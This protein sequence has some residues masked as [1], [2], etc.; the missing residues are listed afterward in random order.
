MLSQ[1]REEQMSSQDPFIHSWGD[2]CVSNPDVSA[3]LYKL[4]ELIK[5]E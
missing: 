3:G 4:V 1:Q 5:C 2:Q